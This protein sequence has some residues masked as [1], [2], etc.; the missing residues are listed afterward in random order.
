MPEGGHGG[1]C[2]VLDL[3]RVPFA[4]DVCPQSFFSSHQILFMVLIYDHKT[5]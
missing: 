2:Q 4:I 5:K 3:G 1:D